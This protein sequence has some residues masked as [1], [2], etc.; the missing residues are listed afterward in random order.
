VALF[1][2]EAFV[3]AEVVITAYP[4][5]TCIFLAFDWDDGAQHADFLGFAI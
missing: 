5:P 2:N 4:S 1:F 3:M